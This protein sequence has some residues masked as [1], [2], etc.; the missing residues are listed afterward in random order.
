MLFVKTIIAI[1]TGI[2]SSNDFDAIICN[3]DSSINEDDLGYNYIL[4]DDDTE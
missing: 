3:R 2:I 4:V 1:V